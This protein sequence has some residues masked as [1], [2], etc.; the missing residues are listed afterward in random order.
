MDLLTFEKDQLSEF[1]PPADFFVRFHAHFRVG[2]VVDTPALAGPF[3]GAERSSCRWE[4]R[5]NTMQP[6]NGKQL[7]D[8]TSCHP[9]VCK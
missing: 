3:E 5:V 9:A 6:I 7:T 8:R 4:D 1:R 2:E